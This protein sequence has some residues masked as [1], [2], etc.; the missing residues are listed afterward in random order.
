M[1]VLPDDWDYLADNLL[2]A[3]L[4]RRSAVTERQKYSQI[5]LLATCNNTSDLSDTKQDPSRMRRYIKRWKK[6]ASTNSV[7]FYFRI[8][9]FR[10]F[11][12]LQFAVFAFRPIVCCQFLARSSIE[13]RPDS[14]ASAS[15][16]RRISTLDRP[17]R[18]I[19]SRSLFPRHP[20]F[21]VHPNVR[22][23]QS[24]IL[25]EFLLGCQIAGVPHFRM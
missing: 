16:V 24:Q 20:L 14:F 2:Q 17:F 4:V 8:F 11:E 22:V 15:A 23:L 6:S 25:T 10:H 21:H 12:V 18:V 5:L 1:P 3:D 19:H 7:I 13:P 9:Y